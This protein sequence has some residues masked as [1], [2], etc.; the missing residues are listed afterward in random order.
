MTLAD[1]I[2]QYDH[3]GT[4]VLLLGKRK[5]I[6]AELH[7]L[8]EL[9][10]QLTS[11]TKHLLFRSGN[12]GGADSL[13]ATGVASIDPGRM[14]VITPY[15][16]HR[17]ANATL[18]KSTSLDHVD[19]ASEP[20]ITYYARLNNPSVN[21]VDRYRDGFRDKSAMKGAYLL[22][23]TLMVIGAQGLYIPKASFAIFYDDLIKPK[24]GGTGHT[25]R[26]CDSL[27]IPFIDQRV[28]ME[29]I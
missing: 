3:P 29:W 21:L 18:F 14:E 4:V 24:D 12:A 15:E 2:A 13:F 19:L 23:D 17:K 28:W 5:V 27:E 11:T 7:L 9:G 22:R 25:M 1:F 10:A 6:P 20:D 8:E 26:V 16:G